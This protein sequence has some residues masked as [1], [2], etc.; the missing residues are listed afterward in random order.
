MCSSIWGETEWHIWGGAKWNRDS[1]KICPFCPP[2]PQKRNDIWE[3]AQKCMGTGKMSCSITSTQQNGILRFKNVWRLAKCPYCT[4]FARI[5]SP[6]ARF[7]APKGGDFESA[8]MHFLN[9]ESDFHLAGV[10]IVVCRSV[11]PV[12]DA[13]WATSFQSGTTLCSRY[14]AFPALCSLSLHPATFS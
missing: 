14:R 13:H 4:N 5:C 1:G 11:S 10:W 7:E 9:L 12:M 6:S 2:P 3:K 8:K